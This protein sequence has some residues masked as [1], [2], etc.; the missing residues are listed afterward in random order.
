MGFPLASNY[1]LLTVDSELSMV[2]RTGVTKPLD[3]AVLGSL[4]EHLSKV[5]ET[6]WKQLKSWSKSNDMITSSILPHFQ[7]CIGRKGLF[8]K[9][10]W[11]ILCILARTIKPSVYNN[12]ALKPTPRHIIPSQTPWGQH[13]HLTVS[14][15]N[16][17]VFLILAVAS[18]VA[19]LGAGI[20]KTEGWIEGWPNLKPN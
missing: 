5:N 16:F 15:C 4:S 17:P 20:R 13:W 18:F 14:K 11:V 7:I 10:K 19:F 8:T 2:Q 6:G 12:I 1:I 3:L 9:P